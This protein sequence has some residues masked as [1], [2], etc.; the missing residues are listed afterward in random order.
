MTVSPNRPD[1]RV[2]TAAGLVVAAAGFAWLGRGRLLPLYIIA[3]VMLALAAVAM[4][5]R[6]W[7]APAAGLLGAAL[8]ALASIAQPH[9]A[10]HLGRPGT[11]GFASTLLMMAGGV[12]AAVGAVAAARAAPGAPRRPGWPRPGWG[13]PLLIGVGG[14]YLAAALGG[15]ALRQV[16]TPAPDP[17]LAAA[18]AHTLFADEFVYADMPSE[19]EAGTAVFELDN[20]GQIEHDLAFEGVDDPVVHAEAGETVRGAVELEAGTHTFYCTIPGHR[21]SG[22]E[23]TVNVTP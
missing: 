8:V 12:L 22:M 1:L 10:Y 7:A 17:S 19:I 9:T 20:V 21:E 5:R 2:L 14:L 6:R 4:H 11:L 3:L 16:T 18:D 13:I 23:G 15:L